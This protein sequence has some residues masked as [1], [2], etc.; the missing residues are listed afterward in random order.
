M[1][2]L[3]FHIARKETLKLYIAKFALSCIIEENSQTYQDF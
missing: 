2:Q 3:D 1:R